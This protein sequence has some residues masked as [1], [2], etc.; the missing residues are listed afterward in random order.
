MGVILDTTVLIGAERER[1]DMPG[2]LESLGEAGVAVAA[3]TAGELLFG[4]EQA[5]DPGIRARRGAFVEAI[6]AA[7]PTAPF[8]LAEARRHAALWA[9][10]AR[11]GELIGPYDMLVAA[12]ALASDL[13]LATLNRGE[14]E[15]VPELSLVELDSF[16]IDRGT[17]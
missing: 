9:E 8:G 6:L 13:S 15:R 3:V 11:R 1:F 2:F 12:T 16:V 5:T 4:F 10:L 7:I 14:F 17:V